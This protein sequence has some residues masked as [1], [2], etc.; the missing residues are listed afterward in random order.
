MERGRGSVV[1]YHPADEMKQGTMVKKTLFLV[2]AHQ[3]HSTTRKRG[4][5]FSNATAIV[6]HTV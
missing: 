2:R 1:P 5:Q 4:S 6:L 3:S